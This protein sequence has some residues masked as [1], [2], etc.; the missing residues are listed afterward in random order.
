MIKYYVIFIASSFHTTENC[1]WTSKCTLCNWYWNPLH[2]KGLF[3]ENFTE[4]HSHAL[5]YERSCSSIWLNF[6]GLCINLKKNG[7]QLDFI[8]QD[9]NWSSSTSHFPLSTWNCHLLKEKFH[10]YD[11]NET[12]WPLKNKTDGNWFSLE[13]GLG[14]ENPSQL[15]QDA[16]FLEPWLLKSLLAH[17]LSFGV[18]EIGDPDMAHHLKFKSAI[19]RFSSEPLKNWRIWDSASLSSEWMKSSTSV[20]FSSRVLLSSEIIRILRTCNDSRAVLKK[21][22]ST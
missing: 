20:L 13:L 14:A 12:S 3:S 10:E 17:K 16:L 4:I 18:H 22:P 6:L 5:R 11:N 15:Y 1:N 19:A 8:Y 9:E 7:D 2:Q 21:P